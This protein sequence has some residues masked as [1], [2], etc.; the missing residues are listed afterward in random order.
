MRK[1]KTDEQHINLTI[2]PALGF[3]SIIITKI[4]SIGHLKYSHVII[5]DSDK[6]IGFHFEKKKLYS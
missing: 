2:R 5:Y 3:F 1:E 6:Q 4:M